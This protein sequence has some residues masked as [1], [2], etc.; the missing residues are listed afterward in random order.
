MEETLK[1]SS[2][3]KYSH[4]VFSC[5][6]LAETSIYRASSTDVDKGSASLIGSRGCQWQLATVSLSHTGLYLSLALTLRPVSIKQVDELSIE[7]SN[8]CMLQCHVDGFF[9]LAILPLATPPCHQS[10]NHERPCPAILLV[11]SSKQLN[12]NYM[13]SSSVMILIV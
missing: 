13:L 3:S 7:L 5:Q 11:S 8:L 1:K 12:G 6:T 4:K 10:L 2:G 9:P